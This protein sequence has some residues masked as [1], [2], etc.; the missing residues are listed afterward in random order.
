MTEKTRLIRNLYWNQSADIKIGNEKSKEV[1][2]QR[3]ARQ[4]CVL[5]PDLFS[6]Y[7][8]NIM[9]E[10]KDIEGIKIG[11]ENIRRNKDRGEN[12]R[13]NKDGRGKHKKE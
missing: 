2:I 6:L 9:E 11:V 4:G 10:I 8:E 3:G 7:S 5:S 1:E 13:R 12:I